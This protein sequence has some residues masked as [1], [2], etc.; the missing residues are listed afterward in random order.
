MK[1]TNVSS[2]IS[3]TDESG[4]EANQCRGIRVPCVACDGNWRTRLLN[5]PKMSHVL[6][7]GRWLGNACDALLQSRRR[8]PRSIPRSRIHKL[9]KEGALSVSSFASP[10][11]PGPEQR[12]SQVGC[13]PPGVCAD[14]HEPSFALI[15]S[16]KG[17]V[18]ALPRE[19]SLVSG[20]ERKG[21]CTL[22]RCEQ[23]SH[24]VEGLG[25]VTLALSRAF[26]YR[27][28]CL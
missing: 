21:G 6:S 18:H 2:V 19:G 17:A 22:W 13:V 7:A 3:G 4:S 20:T 12:F 1:R 27:T 25:A 24:E 15:C 26:Q 5:R 9:R 8:C 10:S 23:F 11:A 16:P 14:L 28:Q